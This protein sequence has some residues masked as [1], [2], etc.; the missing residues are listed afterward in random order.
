MD[1]ADLCRACGCEI[2]GGRLCDSCLN[3][4]WVICSECGDPVHTD[5]AYYDAGTG[6]TCRDCQI[7]RDLAMGEW[8][9]TVCSKSEDPAHACHVGFLEFRPVG[10]YGW[11]R[12]RAEAVARDF[13]RRAETAEARIAELGAN[14]RDACAERARYGDIMTSKLGTAEARVA[15]LENEVEALIEADREK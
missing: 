14:Y 1:T 12:A 10:P 4:G 11:S 3:A 9:C 2:K 15:E 13:L 5:R 8:M 7:T 6:P